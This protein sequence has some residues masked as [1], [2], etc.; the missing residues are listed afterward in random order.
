MRV[1][2]LDLVCQQ[3]QQLFFQVARV[4]AD[5]QVVVVIR[6]KAGHQPALLKYFH[7]TAFAVMVQVFSNFKMVH[8]FVKADRDRVIFHS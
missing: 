8:L 3:M 7:F 6:L 5:V 1:V 2:R 4:L